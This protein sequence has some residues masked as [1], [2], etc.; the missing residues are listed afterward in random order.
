MK[1]R[2]LSIYFPTPPS[3]ES[4][5]E[6]AS[7]LLQF[8]PKVAIRPPEMLYIDIYSTTHLFGGEKKIFERLK[9]FFSEQNVKAKLAIADDIATAG[10]LAH[11]TEGI[12]GKGESEKI[13]SS[14]PIDLLLFLVNPLCKPTKKEIQ[15]ASQMIQVLS[16]LG[17]QTLG[18]L[19]R[20]PASTIGPKFG[21]LGVELHRRARGMESLPF[22]PFEPL[23]HN[24]ESE[25]FN[26]SISH[27]ES[28][29]FI[30]KN[31]L[32]K[33]ED[34]L[35][36]DQRVALGITLY[37][38]T[39]HAQELEVSL[40]FTKPLRID[41]AWFRIIREKLFQVRI[42]APYISMAVEVSCSMK[43][44]PGQF[45]LFD[46]SLQQTEPLGALLERLVAGLGPTVVSAAS[47]RKQ[48]RQKSTWQ[49]VP[50]TPFEQNQ[51]NL[52]LPI[53]CPSNKFTWTSMSLKHCN[54]C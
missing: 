19:A 36:K 32:G 54:P 3:P 16:M 49:G 42:E 6:L 10:A 4:L 22:R 30:L 46:S 1:P 38:E 11:N 34:R 53:T 40:P 18:G 5:P 37:L 41:Q 47:L 14:L 45:R 51:E 28:L 25:T 27:V 20:L 13:L 48:H 44:L 24:R 29:L 21:K 9:I 35:K 26:D 50:F 12:A 8:S 39:E 17:I 43:F 33:L 23:I 2:I 52:I 15:H 31:L 7:L